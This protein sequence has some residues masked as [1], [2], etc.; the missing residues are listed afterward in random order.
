MYNPTAKAST[1]CGRRK[2]QRSFNH[3]EMSEQERN[4]FNKAFNKY[5]ITSQKMMCIEE[6]AELTNA[7]A[8]LAR[9]R[10]SQMDIITELADV[11]IM[12]DQMAIFFGEELFIKERERKMKLL[13]ERLLKCETIIH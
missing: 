1:V 2:V 5:G 11:S 13:E 6:C 8:K 3:T 10:V 7:L 12:V 9:G 4:I